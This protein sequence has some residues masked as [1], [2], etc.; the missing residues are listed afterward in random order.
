MDWFMEIHSMYLISFIVF[1]VSM[2]ASQH[3]GDL[4]GKKL[5]MPWHTGKFVGVIFAALLVMEHQIGLF[6]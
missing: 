6:L 1:M 2:S 4:T 3:L 5:E